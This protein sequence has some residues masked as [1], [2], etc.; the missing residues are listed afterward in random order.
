MG[1]LLKVFGNNFNGALRTGA[2]FGIDDPLLVIS[3]C[4]AVFVEGT[5]ILV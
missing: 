2:Q 3:A 1:I 5:F 4:A